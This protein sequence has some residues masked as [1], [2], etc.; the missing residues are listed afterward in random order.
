MID[1]ARIKQS[2]CVGR[3]KS[4]IRPPYEL[5]AAQY[6]RLKI[7][8]VIA[9]RREV[10]IHFGCGPVNDPRFI[11]IDARV[12][13]HVHLV[14]NSPMLHPLTL[15][16][17][18]SIYGCH[19]FEHISHRHQAA[20][21]RRW[22]EILKPGGRLM[23]SVPDFDKLMVR[24]AAGGSD[25]RAIEMPLM[26]AQEYPG[27]FHCAIFTRQHLAGLL[28]KAGF[29]NPAEWHPRNEREWPR[30]W[31]WDESVSLN[32]SAVKPP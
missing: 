16:S 14:T 19:V 20:V 29:I 1:F 10:H 25:P 3:L 6:R 18:D 31:S 24:Y 4:V 13:K 7:S 12:Y 8:S 9:D 11:N 5:F 28:D 32:L 2:E 30:D 22:L 17:A 27:N 15:N 23:L 21:L 26:G